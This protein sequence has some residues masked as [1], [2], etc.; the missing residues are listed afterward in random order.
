[1]WLHPGIYEMPLQHVFGVIMSQ[2]ASLINV[3]RCL[4]ISNT[5]I[6]QFSLEVG[7]NGQAFTFLRTYEV[8]MHVCVGV[9]HFHLLVLFLFF[10]FSYYFIFY[11]NVYVFLFFIYILFYIGFITVVSLA[12]WLFLYTFFP[13]KALAG[14]F[15][16]GQVILNNMHHYPCSK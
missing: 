1:M 5:H 11:F 16:S 14:N 10:L 15:F 8:C 6:F 12:L 9:L 13:I 3:A 7:K 2:R 4:Q